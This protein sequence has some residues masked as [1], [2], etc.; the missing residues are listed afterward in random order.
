MNSEEEIQKIIKISESRDEFVTDVD[1]YVYWWP[2]N[3]TQGH[4]S[5][6]QLRILA[7]ELD[8]RNEGWDKQIKEYFDRS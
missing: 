6:F 5:S 4:F 1:G 2:S 8:R 3:P 7:D